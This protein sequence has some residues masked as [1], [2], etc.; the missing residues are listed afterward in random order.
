MAH[1]VACGAIG[2][3]VIS[4]HRPF[5]IISEMHGKVLDIEGANPAPGTSVIMLPKHHERQKNQLWYFD[6][7]KVIRSAL[8]D[9]VLEAS[10][11][12]ANI[13]IMSY[14][15]N[16]RQH[17]TLQGNAIMNG[18]EE[19][20]DIDAELEE[21]GAKLISY[22]YKGS[23]N[24]HWRIEYGTFRSRVHHSI[25]FK[26]HGFG[27]LLQQMRYYEPVLFF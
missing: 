5:Y 3:S 20:L 8:S 23:Q 26:R 13:K 22:S 16:P 18:I 4:S 21:D 11:G 6:D 25:D 9:C 17:W 14:T 12:E 10:G 27:F 1:G 2:R 15:G 7:Q 24:Q 19:C